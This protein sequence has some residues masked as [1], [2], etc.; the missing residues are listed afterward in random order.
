LD[1]KVDELLRKRRSFPPRFAAYY[2]LVE[3]CGLS[4][5]ETAAALGVKPPSISW[6]IRKWKEALSKKKPN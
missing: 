5:S 2:H 4:V 3:N 1:V 6:G